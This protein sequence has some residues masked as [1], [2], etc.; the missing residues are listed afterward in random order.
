MC[1]FNIVNYPNGFVIIR[2]WNDS[3]EIGSKIVLPLPT[4][5]DP[6][7]RYEHPVPWTN[8]GPEH[9]LQ[10]TA[11]ELQDFFKASISIHMCT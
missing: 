3:I 6:R 11:Q 4:G 7:P 5:W 9:Y 2:W 1:I 8:I 10:P